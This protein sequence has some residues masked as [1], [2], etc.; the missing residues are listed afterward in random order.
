MK[1][2]IYSQQSFVLP[3]LQVV[4]LPRLKFSQIFPDR[5]SP[6]I[7]HERVITRFVSS[8]VSRGGRGVSLGNRRVINENSSASSKK[9]D[10]LSKKRLE[11]TWRVGMED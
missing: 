10:A 7:S 3:S 4:L 2:A 1:R 9:S 8:H 5:Y 6:R 11:A